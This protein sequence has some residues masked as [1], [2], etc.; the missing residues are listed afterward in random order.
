MSPP[1]SPHLH[2][3][4]V[5]DDERMRDTLA[6]VL[7]AEGHTVET[8]RD[9]RE[10]LAMFS[11]GRFQLI[12]TDLSMPHMPGDALAARIKALCPTQAIILVTALAAQPAHRPL[13]QVDYLLPKPFKIDQL[14]H[15]I[16]AVAVAGGND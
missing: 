4:V 16:A 8:S 9:G 10:A 11:P 5:D 6:R 1:P 15:A 3:L 2:I 13:P 7:R 12:M 14:A